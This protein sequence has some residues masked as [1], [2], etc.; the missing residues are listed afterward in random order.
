MTMKRYVTTIALAALVFAVSCGGDD[1]Q[2]PVVPGPVVPPDPATGSA[3]LVNLELACNQRNVSE[4]ERIL[5]SGFMF[6][7]APSDV[8]GSVPS[9]WGRTDEVAVISRMFTR[10]TPPGS[11]VRSLTMDIDSAII[12]WLAIVPASA[13]DEIWYTTTAFYDFRMLI[14]PDAEYVTVPGTKAQFTV[15]NAGTDVAPRWRL[16]EMR[17]LGAPASAAPAAVASTD[18][19]TWGAAKAFFR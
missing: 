3:V 2:A 13:P 1:P 11:L 5:D 9:E 6:Y 14:D 7:F 12:Q 19:I 17:D 4:Y 8:G 18:D 16:V 15:R 10:A